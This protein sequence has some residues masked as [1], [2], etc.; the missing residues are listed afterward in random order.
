MLS[1]TF[2]IPCNKAYFLVN[3]KEISNLNAQYDFHYP[4]QQSSLFSEFLPSEFLE[5]ELVVGPE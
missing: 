3:V 1:M 2:I 5:G 4:L